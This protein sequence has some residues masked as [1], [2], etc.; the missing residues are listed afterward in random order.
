[1]SHTTVSL[2]LLNEAAIELSKVL[3]AAGVKHAFCG[4]YLAQTF[5]MPDR[6]TVD[7]DC[8][9]E[10]GFR[11]ASEAL[12]ASGKFESPG[13]LSTGAKRFYY[14]LPGAAPPNTHVET[15]PPALPGTAASSTAGDVSRAESPIQNEKIKVELLTAGEFGPR[16]ITDDKTVFAPVSNNANTS[17]K[18]RFLSPSEFVR[19]KIK[20]W[21]NRQSQGDAADVIWFLQTFGDQLEVDRVNPDGGMDNLADADKAVEALWSKLAEG[22]STDGEVET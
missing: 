14:I 10:G 12:L 6:Q 21:T 9:I 1:M 2:N 18:L 15:T 7:V 22:G 16:F 8:I 11:K 3:T 19:T 20:A 5:G 4:G 17:T 13:G